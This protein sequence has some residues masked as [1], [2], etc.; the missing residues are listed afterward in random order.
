VNADIVLYSSSYVKVRTIIRIS[1]FGQYSSA[2]ANQIFDASANQ[3]I[4]VKMQSGG[5]WANMPSETPDILPTIQLELITRVGAMGST[6]TAGPTGPQGL[7]GSTGPSAPWT[8]SGSTIYYNSGSVGIGKTSAS[9]TLD[10]LGKQ[11]ITNNDGLAP[12]VLVN[13]G[14]YNTISFKATGSGAGWGQS[15][16]MENTAATGRSYGIYSSSEGNF[17]ITDITGATARVTL[18]PNGYVGIGTGTAIT[19]AYPLHLYTANNMYGMVHAVSG[20]AMGTFINSAS[21][22]TPCQ[23]GTITNHKL[24]FYTNNGAP[25]VTIGTNGYLGVGTSSPTWPL[26]VVGSAQTGTITAN[27]FIQVGGAAVIN[28]SNL[29]YNWPFSIVTSASVRLGGDCVFYSDARIKTNIS[30]IND[31]SALQ[32]FRLLAPKTYRYVDQITRTSEV[33]YGFIAQEVKQVIPH[34]VGLQVEFIPNFYMLGEI[35]YNREASFDESGNEVSIPITQDVSGVEDASASYVVVKYEYTITTINTMTFTPLLDTSGNP[36]PAEKQKYRIRMYD[37]TNNKYECDVVSINSSTS[38]TVRTEERYKS[39]MHPDPFPAKVFVYGQE[40]NDFH[41]LKKD[42]IWT[43]A[44]AALQ[45]VDRQQ[46]A[47]K[48]RIAVLESKVSTLETTIA[49]LQSQLAAVLTHLNM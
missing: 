1:T 39:D 21:A 11:T 4:G 42:A 44:T 46:L 47:D 26:H 31:D 16:V 10:I 49:T 24:G 3:R 29:T 40:V 2:D 33:V 32:Q 18:S 22:Y 5:F 41:A 20:Y 37:S 35:V 7:T 23:F 38:I 43:I 48:E 12:T 15:V 8:T 9:T 14:S 30:D 34:A 25:N 17:Y 45:E 28:N 27:N 13:S 36:L 19:N 6:G